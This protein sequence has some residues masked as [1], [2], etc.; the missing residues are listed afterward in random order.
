[1][2]NDLNALDMCSFSIICSNV[3]TVSSKSFSFDSTTDRSSGLV[4]I[5]LTFR[6]IARSLEMGWKNFRKPN[7]VDGF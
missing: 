1:M 4:E 5:V 2:A 3:G 7:A 6:S